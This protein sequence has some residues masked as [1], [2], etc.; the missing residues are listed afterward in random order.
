MS[1]N[2][3]SRQSTV[4][5]S[6]ELDETAFVKFEQSQNDTVKIKFLEQHPTPKQNQ[7]GSVSYEFEVLDMDSQTIKTFGITSKRLMRMLGDHLPIEGKVFCIKRIGQGMDTTY[8]VT[9]V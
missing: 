7:F 5:T 1:D 6:G 9:I 3:T 8:E 2:N 4:W